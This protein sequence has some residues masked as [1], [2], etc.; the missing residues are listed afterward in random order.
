MK[1]TL[2]LVILAFV[3]FI[4]TLYDFF[5]LAVFYNIYH[6][7]AAYFLAL[8]SLASYIFFEN[9]MFFTNIILQTCFVQLKMP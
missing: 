8:Q 5:A 2:C 3:V 9:Y 7:V 4:L 1:Q 6:T